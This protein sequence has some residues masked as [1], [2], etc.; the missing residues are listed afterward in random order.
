[1]KIYVG[2]L[3]EKINSDHLKTAF[4]DFGKVTSAKVITD[5]YTGKSRGFGFVEMP[6]EEEA[7]NVIKNVNS[8]TWEGKVIIVKKART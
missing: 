3:D 7:L 1:M 5:R 8:G 2:N 6:V 4:Q